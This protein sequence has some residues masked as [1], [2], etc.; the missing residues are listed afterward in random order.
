MEY[1]GRALDHEDRILRGIRQFAPDI[2]IHLGDVCFGDYEQWHEKL[3]EATG[4]AKRWLIRGNH[5]VNS[6]TWYIE[7]GWDFVGQLVQMDRLGLKVIFTHALYAG[8]L[9]VE[10]VSIHG[11]NHK[12]IRDKTNCEIGLH[13]PDNNYQPYSLDS[14]LRQHQKGYKQKDEN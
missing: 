13:L 4:N 12:S 2:L 8:L 9:P 3:F 7:H 14:L 6:Y 10:G 1:D 11:H 5:D